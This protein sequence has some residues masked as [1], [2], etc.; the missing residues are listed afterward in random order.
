LYNTKLTPEEK[1]R[2]AKGDFKTLKEKLWESDKQITKALKANKSNYDIA[3]LQGA[4]SI[5]D[6][7]IEILDI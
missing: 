2:I 6:R 1:Q 7:L 3:F 5:V 4:S